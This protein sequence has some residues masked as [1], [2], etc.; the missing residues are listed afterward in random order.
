MSVKKSSFG[1][2]DLYTITNAA[3]AKIAVSSLG[4][5]VQSILMPD[6]NGALGDVVVGFDTAQEYLN[7]TEYT[8]AAVG[9]YANRIG[10]GGFTLNGKEYKITVNEGKNTLHGGVGFHHRRFDCVCVGDD[11]VTM[12]LSDPDGADGFPGSLEFSVRYKLTEDNCLIIDY[13]AQSDKDTV[14]NFTNHSYFNLAGQGTA[15]KH[16]LTVNADN[17]LEV[18]DG[19]IPT[20]KLVPVAGTAFDF[21][22]RRVIENGF[23]DHCYVLKDG[24]C[25]ELFERESGRK[26]TVTT[27]MPAVQVYVGGSMRTRTGKNGVL[28]FKNSA[29]CLE[30]QFY[31]DAPNKPDFPSTVL[32]AGEVFSSRT[33]YA[34]SVE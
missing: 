9:R 30:T 29:V 31:P 15:L 7:D 25:A 4:A 34:F 5:T 28:N 11:S 26:M 12:R 22:K 13:T 3:G 21:T 24:F 1:E 32:K 17:Y 8:G 20:G 10:N 18:D 2:Y 14:V 27:D 16:E 6:R 33:V 23:Y 19:L